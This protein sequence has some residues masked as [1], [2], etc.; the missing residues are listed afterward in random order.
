[1]FYFVPAF[2]ISKEETDLDITMRM[3]LHSS[4]SAVLII[5]NNLM[6]SRE[7]WHLHQLALGHFTYIILHFILSLL[8]T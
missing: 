3:R 2:L 1:M 5:L 8:P 7:T 6:D 4:M